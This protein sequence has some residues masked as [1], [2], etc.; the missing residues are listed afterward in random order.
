MSST[1]LYVH[2]GLMVRKYP[3]RNGVSLCNLPDCN[4]PLFADA[5]S[6]KYGNTAM[7]LNGASRWFCWVS[8]PL[9]GR[10]LLEYTYT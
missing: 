6:P 9:N 1:N 2:R 10:R 7:E 4:T 8:G 5:E 3:E